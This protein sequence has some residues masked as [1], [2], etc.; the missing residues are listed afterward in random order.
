MKT[1]RD[2]MQGSVV[3]VGPDDPLLSVHRLFVQQEISGAPVV[4]ETGRLLGV[5][6]ATDLLRGVEEEHDT[7]ATEPRYLRDYMEFSG[8][9]WADTPEDFQDRLAERTVAEVMTP[10]GVSVTPDTPVPDLAKT[11]R[12][13]RVHRVLVLEGETLVGIVST[14]DLVG[15]LESQP[16]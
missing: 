16:A 9:D 6:S 13:N 2:V 15:L 1:T 5:V 8:P 12:Q 3:T 10:G 4:D 7:A 14:F 11:M